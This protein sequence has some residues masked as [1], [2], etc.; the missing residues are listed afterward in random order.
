MRART[1]AAG[2]Y[3]W[4][5]GEAPEVAAGAVAFYPSAASLRHLLQRWSKTQIAK[6]PNWAAPRSWSPSR[7]LPCG[8]AEEARTRGFAAPAF[9]GC[10]LDERC[11]VLDMARCGHCQEH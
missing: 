9:A 5:S 11:K 2:Q 6:L 1:D 8:A 3:G 7:R 10:A 4:T